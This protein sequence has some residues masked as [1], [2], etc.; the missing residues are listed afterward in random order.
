MRNGSVVP[1]VALLMSAAPLAAR[2]QAE[3]AP[4]PDSSA[5][6]VYTKDGRGATLGQLLSAAFPVDVVFLG[7]SHNDVVGHSLQR[8]IFERL[9]QYARGMPESSAGNA[10]VALPRPMALSLEM[11]E[12]DVQYII[13]EYLAGLIPEDQ[14]K[15][16]ARPWPF[17][18]DDYAPVVEIAKNAGLPVLAANAPRRYVNAVSRKGPAALE[19][20]S[21][22]AKRHLPPLPYAGPSAA[23]RA[24]LM[25]VMGQHGDSTSAPQVPEGA[26]SAQSLWD[27]TMAWSIAGALMRSPGALVVHLVGSFHVKNATGIPEQLQMYRPGTRVLIVYVEPVDDVTAFPPELVGAGDFVILTDKAKVRTSQT[28]GS[29]GQ[30]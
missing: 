23:Y 17:Y 7:E 19:A 24:E 4:A 18:A 26:F 13:D 12:R 2:Q 22:E 3:P 14:M 21:T 16:S 29:T 25:A 6:R 5:Y 20:F 11:F 8:L 9:V 30:S 1:I 27:A 28:T 10:V 15:R